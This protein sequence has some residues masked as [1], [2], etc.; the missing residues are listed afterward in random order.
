MLKK[1]Q[2]PTYLITKT[3]ICL[4]SK[5]TSQSNDSL[6]NLFFVL[7]QKILIAETRLNVFLEDISKLL[8]T[9]TILQQ[10]LLI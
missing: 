1:N 6:N 4:G 3:F 2:L 5:M 10:L 8:W 9:K 7:S